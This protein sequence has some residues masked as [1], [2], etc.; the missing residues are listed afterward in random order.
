MTPRRP[1]SDPADA[2]LQLLGLR[3]ETDYGTGPPARWSQP[4]SSQVVGV[5]TVAGALVVGFLLTAG[6]VA[7]REAAA[8]QTARKSQLV[9]LVRDRQ[10][11]TAELSARLEELRAQLAAAEQAVSAAGADAL[12]R[13]LQAVEAAIGLTALRGPGARV[14]FGDAKGTCPTGRPEDCRIQDTDLQLAINELWA[15]GAEGVAVNGERIIA[16]T[17]VRNAGSAILVNYRVLTSPYVLDAVG[18]PDALHTGFLATQLAGDFRVWQESFGLAFAATAQRDL[19][20]PS[21]TGG[22]QLDSTAVTP[23]EDVS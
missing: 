10:E 20:L 17:A 19:T 6:M 11:R 14:T 3:S 7:G 15:L 5:L 12:R 16:T 18:D 9:A 4:W 1:P 23:G 8:E 2:A 22:L 13:D 21:Y